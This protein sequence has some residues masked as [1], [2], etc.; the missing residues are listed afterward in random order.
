[1]TQQRI[2]PA[3]AKFDPAHGV[4]SEN[5]KNRT[6]SRW[7]D[8]S[9]RKRPFLRGVCEKPTYTSAGIER[10]CLENHSRIAWLN[11]PS[12]ENHEKYGFE[13]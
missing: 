7:H 9:S 8:L 2:K 10:H 1:M 11:Q 3:Y 12:F 13:G 6:V 5:G 4:A